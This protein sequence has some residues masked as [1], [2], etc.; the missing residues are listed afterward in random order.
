[1]SSK[2]SVNLDPL[3]YPKSVAVIG[4]SPNVIRDRGGFFYSLKECYGGKLYGVNPKYDDI[5]GVPCFPSIK[6]IPEKIDYALIM[7]PREK[8]NGVLKDCVTAGVKFVLV[9]TSGFSEMGEYE[10]E[11][12]LLETIEGSGTRIIGPNCIGPHCPEHGLAYYAQLHRD[13]VGEVGFFSQS[14]GH[15]LNFTIRG[16]S[17]GLNF[18]KVISLGNQADLKIED[19]LEYFGNDDRVKIICGYAEDVKDGERFK[20][21]AREIV[22]ERR[23]PLVLWKGGR[24]SDGA[25]ATSSHTGAVAV[26]TRVW[27]SVMD[28]LGV[29]NV[30]SQNE[31]ADV[32]IALKLG[33]K[34]KGRNTVI[35]VAG[36]GSS[37]ELTDGASLNGLHVP[38]LAADIQK[39]IGEDIS[40]VNTSTNNPI[41]LGMFGFAPNIF[42][43]SMALAA[44]DPNIDI[45]MG[46]QYP[47]MVKAMAP[48]AW[49]ASVS[50][51]IDGIDKVGKPTAM[52]LPRLNENSADSEGVRA[53]FTEK[54]REI[55]VPAFPSAARMARAAV[56]IQKYIDFM[57]KHGAE[58]TF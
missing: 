8:V 36:G 7:L 20:R 6:D 44:E 33:F 42:V 37:V 57:E 52:I 41:D 3:F 40:S 32:M 15:A 10:L 56:K 27:D 26:P 35:A 25:R 43:R 51:L 19:F 1:M 39:K 16:L 2:N 9:F 18:N 30:E 38:S 29:I 24:S 58:V 50:I 5:E 31:L 55:N 21:V 48:E 54:L 28:Q 17:I 45:V 49:D 34:P 46:C 53:E 11:N 14:G 4:A 12:E 13:E 22:L 47:E 23:K